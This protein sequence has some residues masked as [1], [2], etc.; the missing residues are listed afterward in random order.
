[1]NYGL[2]VYHISET[3]KTSKMLLL[4]QY[5]VIL[6]YYISVALKMTNEDT[7][8]LDYWIKYKTFGL[9]IWLVG[10]DFGKKLGKKN[11][12]SIVW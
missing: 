3:I 11:K 4:N 8:S 7:Q 5:K 1:M 12:F 10:I 9:E 2:N 6:M